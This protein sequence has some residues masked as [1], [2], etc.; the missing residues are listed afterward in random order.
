MLDSHSKM[1]G[2]S[3][4]ITSGTITTLGIM[5][6]MYSSTQSVLAVIGGIIA[7][8]IADGFSDAMGIHVSEES[9]GKHTK[10]EIWEA[11]LSTFFTKLLYT[12]TFIIAILLLPIQTAI[13]VNIVYGLLVLAVFSYYLGKK[14]GDGLHMVFEHVT[15]AVAVIIITY[16]VG[17]FV[18]G[19]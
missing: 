6:G 1:V 15:I 2:F 19:F 12:M 3:F 18:A 11:T 9:E 17:M 8:A 13:V 5:V 4:G 10:S 16:Y 14:D 7:V